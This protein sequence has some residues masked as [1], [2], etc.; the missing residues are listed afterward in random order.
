LLTVVDN[1]DSFTFNLVQMLWSLGAELRVVRNDEAAAVDL[2]GPETKGVVLSPG[3]GWPS[4][5]GV[6]AELLALR[7]SLPIL[8]VC[9][10]H[11]VL[12]AEFGADVARAPEPVHGKTVEVEHNSRGIFRDV[13]NPFVA[14]RYHS[15]HVPADRLPDVLEVSATSSDGVIMAIRHVHLPYWGVQ[16]H[17]ESIL[18]VE[19]VRIVANFV[20]LCSRGCDSEMQSKGRSD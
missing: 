19:G 7:P 1:Y 10:G 8:G 20:E 4:E 16:F 12:A 17:P 14:T 11:Q 6:S 9:L 2:L 13:A 15:L 3:P 18:T 5:S